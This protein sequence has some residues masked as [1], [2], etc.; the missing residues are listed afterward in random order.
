[1]QSDIEQPREPY[2][3]FVS[4]DSIRKHIKAFKPPPEGEMGRT[5]T[6]RENAFIVFRQALRYE[7]PFG[8]KDGPKFHIPFFQLPGNPPV[9]AFHAL[10]YNYLS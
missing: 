10:F 2:Y 3:L 7:R 9:N 1:M 8:K 5:G 6:R 4:R